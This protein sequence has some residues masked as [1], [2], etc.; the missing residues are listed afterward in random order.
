[1]GE[2]V[3]KIQMGCDKRLYYTHYPIDSGPAFGGHIDRGA[4]SRNRRGISGARARA[5]AAAEGGKTRPSYT[6]VRSMRKVGKYKPDNAGDCRAIIN[7]VGAP[8]F[9]LGTSCSQSSAILNQ[10]RYS[11]GLHGGTE[12]RC[13]ALEDEK[14]KAPPRLRRGPL[15]E[16][17]E[18][19]TYFVGRSSSSLGSDVKLPSF[20]P[21][22]Q[23]VFPT[24]S[25]TVM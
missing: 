4:R 14:K 18:L 11:A 13:A 10:T 1:M 7:S 15:P 22:P 23:P 6:T 2:A 8:G 17:W 25:G 12:C 9:E 16:V 20:P 3:G 5:R 24:W 21:G 19:L